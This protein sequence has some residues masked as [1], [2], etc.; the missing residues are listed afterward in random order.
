MSKQEDKENE[1]EGGRL[2]ETG[3]LAVEAAAEA[4]TKEGRTKKH[5]QDKIKRERER[6]A[7]K[8]HK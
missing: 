3:S 8:R 5:Q 2:R 1:N 4:V 6:R 7:E